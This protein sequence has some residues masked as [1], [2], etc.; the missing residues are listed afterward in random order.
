MMKKI[1]TVLFLAFSLPCIAMESLAK[2][3]KKA[4]QKDE[5]IEVQ[6]DASYLH[7]QETLVLSS[8]F[9]FD[10]EIA[11]IESFISSFPSYALVLSL[12][13]VMPADIQSII[14]QFLYDGSNVED[15]LKSRLG[16]V[17]CSTIR[18]KSIIN[19]SRQIIVDKIDKQL[20]AD[21]NGDVML[22]SAENGEC[23]QSFEKRDHSNSYYH[24]VFS[25]DD[26][27]ILLGCRANDYYDVTL[28]SVES[29]RCLQTFKH[30]AI[31]SH[32]SKAYSPIFRFNAAENRVLIACRNLV[33]VWS[34]ES[35]E[36]LQAFR[37]KE[38]V[39]AAVFNGAEDEILTISEG[40]INE[41]EV[42]VWSLET[43]ECLPVA[44]PTIIPI[45][46]MY[47]LKVLNGKDIIC[48]SLPDGIFK[49]ISKVTGNCIQTF[50]GHEQ[51]VKKL[52]FTRLEDKVLS[53]SLGGVVKLWSIESGQCLQTFHHGVMD[54]RCEILFNKAEDRILTYTTGYASVVKL[55]SAETGECLQVFNEQQ[56]SIKYVVGKD[57]NHVL[58][59]Y[60][61]GT[62]K[63]VDISF[64]ERLKSSLTLFQSYFLAKIRQLAKHRL[65][66]KL[67]EDEGIAIHTQ[68]G[69]KVMQEHLMIHCAEYRRLQDAYEALPQK[70]QDIC[71]EYV[72]RC[73]LL[74][75]AE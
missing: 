16:V 8:F 66:L 61:D 34:I 7:A 17:P 51:A 52:L 32:P 6:D 56:G 73:P 42:T 18:V 60:Y 71:D 57:A 40:K 58:I 23:L 22:L 49:F 46:Q 31:P 48:M 64:W 19:Y 63:I 21:Q 2:K 37:H 15:F 27:K 30:G 10:E 68:D 62:I 12:C 1:L 25:K 9:P 41:A 24:A 74:R 54:W 14:A 70:I 36:C 38:P 4:V 75:E 47:S 35:G 33:T 69:K 45:Y 5:L 20:V 39:Y 53:S 65:W 29:G 28:L 50:R 44:I 72:R 3:S 67:K 13:R 26:D 43:G 59:M 11:D 55:W